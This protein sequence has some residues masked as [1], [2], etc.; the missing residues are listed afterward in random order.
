MSK[1]TIVKSHITPFIKKGD[2][3]VGDMHR[4]CLLHIDN[5]MNMDTTYKTLYEYDLS[6]FDNSRPEQFAASHHKSLKPDNIR[7]K[8]IELEKYNQQLRE[9]LHGSE[10]IVCE[11][12]LIK[13]FINKLLDT[14]KTVV[15]ISK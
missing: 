3:F 13:E 7:W 4:L 1:I 12:E 6:S 15:S 2:A 11:N 5:T 8:T 10:L 14:E 9:E